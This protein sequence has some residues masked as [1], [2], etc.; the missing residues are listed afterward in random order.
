MPPHRSGPAVDGSR[1]SGSG[2]AQAQCERTVSAKPPRWPM[3]VALDSPQNWWCPDRHSPQCMQLSAV[4]PTPTRWPTFSPLAWSPTATTRPMTSWPSTAGYSLLPHSLF[5]TERSEWQMPQYSTLTSTSS[6]PRGAAS[7]S[8][9]SNAA[10]AWGTTHDLILD[11]QSS[12]QY[13]YEFQ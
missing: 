10:P 5:F 6:D 9:S 4:Q 1:F 3:I 8:C 11:M 7:S 2:I 12:L 13:S